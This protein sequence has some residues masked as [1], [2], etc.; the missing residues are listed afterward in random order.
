KHHMQNLHVWT[1]Q[2]FPDKTEMCTQLR[3]VEWKSG[4][5]R[6]KILRSSGARNRTQDVNPHEETRCDE[7]PHRAYRFCLRTS[8]TSCSAVTNCTKGDRS[9]IIIP[10]EGDLWED[11][12]KD[13]KRPEDTEHRDI[14]H[15]TANS[16]S[17]I[18]T[19]IY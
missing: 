15:F 18:R 3:E 12:S 11:H 4:R 13:G 5:E 14:S 17:S 8:T 2:D 6:E 19:H 10:E 1:Y 7:Y 9:L 16:I